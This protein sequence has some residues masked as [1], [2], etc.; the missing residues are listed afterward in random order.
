MS[1]EVSERNGKNPFVIKLTNQQNLFL[2][3]F[4]K[5]NCASCLLLFE[6]GEIFKRVFFV[7]NISRLFPWWLELQPL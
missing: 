7:F 1:F 4:F 5:K 6:K 3:I 2:Y